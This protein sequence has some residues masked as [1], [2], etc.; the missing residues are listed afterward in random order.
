MPILWPLAKFLFHVVG[1]SIPDVVKTVTTLKQQHPQ[2]APRGERIQEHF[3]DV[4]RKLAQQLE[5]IESLTRQCELIHQIAR[6]ALI[7]GGLAIALALIA[8]GTVFLTR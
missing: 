3:L 5:M 7:A 8:V 2:T 6:K 1:P 4:E